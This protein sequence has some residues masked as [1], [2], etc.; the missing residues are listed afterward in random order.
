MKRFYKLVS[1][2]AQDN[3][4]AIMLDGR[5]VKTPSKNTLIA[6]NEAIANLIV[7]EWAAQEEEVKP[8]TMPIMQI[9]TTQQEKVAH[10]RVA[11]TEQ[12]LKYLDT[13]LICYLSD[14]MPGLEDAQEAAWKPH[15]SWFEKTYD[16]TLETTK[17]IAALSHPGKAHQGARKTVEALSDAHFTLLQIITPMSG[18]LILALAF[19]DSAA[20]ADDILKAAFV[21]EDFKDK[22]Y[23]AEKYGEDP[24]IAKKKDGLSI[25]LK[26]AEQYLTAL[27]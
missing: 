4:Y 7:K 15:R 3:G 5:P 9:L 26:A 23:N 21:E 18:S 2:Q 1:T 14:E 6:P 22:L 19:L 12:V 20:S 13:D 10:E 24:M 25:D 17:A 27:Q 8:D 11:M 16:V